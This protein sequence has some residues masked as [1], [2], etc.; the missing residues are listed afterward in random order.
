MG[1]DFASGRPNPKPV[2]LF[3]RVYPSRQQY[4]LPKEEEAGEIVKALVEVLGSRGC[5]VLGY[6]MPDQPNNTAVVLINGNVVECAE[7]IEVPDP[8]IPE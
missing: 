5:M 1:V 4:R 2:T 8:Q 3:L 6:E 7:L